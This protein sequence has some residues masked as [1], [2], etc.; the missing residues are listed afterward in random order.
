M[1]HFR[2]P[3]PSSTHAIVPMGLVPPVGVKLTRAA[4]RPSG[5]METS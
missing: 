4:R 5:F 3:L 2:S 1:N